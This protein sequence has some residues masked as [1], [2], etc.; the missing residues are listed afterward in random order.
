M[1]VRLV[2][3]DL[4]LLL[5]EMYSASAD[6]TDK[7]GQ[8]YDNGFQHFIRPQKHFQPA[9]AG[10]ESLNQSQPNSPRRSSQPQNLPSQIEAVSLLPERNTVYTT[11]EPCPMA[12]PQCG[13]QDQAHKPGSWLDMHP[14]TLRSL[15]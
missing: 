9:P 10:V 7:S 5:L 8:K 6:A 15:S 12:F 13:L 1:N 3:F 14:Y 4:G 11:P 2:K